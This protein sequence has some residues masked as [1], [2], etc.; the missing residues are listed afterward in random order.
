MLTKDSKEIYII[1]LLSY[2]AYSS[3]EKPEF[4]VT[5]SGY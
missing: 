1:T 4:H 3:I 2:T 5:G